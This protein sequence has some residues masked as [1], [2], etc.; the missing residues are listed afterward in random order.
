MNRTSLPISPFT[1]ALSGS[2]R[3]TELRIRS[4]FQ[5]LPVEAQAPA[6]APA[7]PPAGRRPP[8][9]QPGVLPDGGA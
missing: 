3:E 1:T 7:D 9:R 8:V 4:I 6:S 5:H 2:A